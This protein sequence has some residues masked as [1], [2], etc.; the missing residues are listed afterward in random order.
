MRISWFALSPHRS[1]LE[2][3]GGEGRG[4]RSGGDK[5][6]RVTIFQ[7]LNFEFA[8]QTKMGNRKRRKSSEI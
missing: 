6:N 7:S 8:A 5:K 1:F 2:I 3:W 4:A